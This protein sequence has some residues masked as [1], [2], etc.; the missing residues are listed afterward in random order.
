VTLEWK[1][2]KK[3]TGSR[4]CRKKSKNRNFSPKIKNFTDVNFKNS[5]FSEN[6]DLLPW[7]QKSLLP[8]E[9]EE[10]TCEREEELKIKLEKRECEE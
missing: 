1:A 5:N 8:S 9:I 6:Y 4:D 10:S 7:V 3:R 2:G